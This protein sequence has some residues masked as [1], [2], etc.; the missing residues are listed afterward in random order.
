MS[1]S[2]CQ[3]VMSSVVLHYCMIKAQSLSGDPLGIPDRR[4]DK[5]LDNIIA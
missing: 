5:I 2:Y 1:G 4:T 3:S